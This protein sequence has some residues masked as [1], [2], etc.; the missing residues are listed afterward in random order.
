MVLIFDIYTRTFYEGYRIYIQVLENFQT[1]IDK[2][3]DVFK[4]LLYISLFFSFRLLCWV[5]IADSIILG[6]R[7]N[8]LLFFL[9]EIHCNS[10]E[11]CFIRSLCMDDEPYCISGRTRQAYWRRGE[12]FDAFFCLWK[13]SKNYKTGKKSWSSRIKMNRLNKKKKLIIFI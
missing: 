10:F 2:S 11:F 3:S 8:L 12:Q 9:W 1:F 7:L 5:C 13:F 6:L 4:T